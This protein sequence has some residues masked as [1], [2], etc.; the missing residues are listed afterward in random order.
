MNKSAK[1]PEH[2]AVYERLR[3]MILLGQLA[4]GQKLTIM[5]MAKDLN[6][7]MTPTREAIRR[8]TAE[9]AISALGNRR[10]A[11]PER[12][13]KDLDDIYSLRLMIE[14]ELARRAVNSISNQNVTDLICMDAAVDDALEKGDIEAYLEANNRF[15]FEIYRIADAPVLFNVVK[16]LWVQVGPSLR[17][18]SGRYGTAN[19]PDKHS[20][21][22]AAFKERSGDA[23]AA[24]MK[25]DLDQSLS[26][27]TRTPMD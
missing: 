13:Q 11:V 17:V 14:P 15:H 24:A 9:N 20:E 25:G 3:N 23:A 18:I 2:Q 4:P 16:S 27:V 21:L 19:L 22:L 12:S 1:I 8:L 5:G 26:L 7:G 10:V 6:A